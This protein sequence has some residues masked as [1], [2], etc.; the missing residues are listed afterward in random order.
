VARLSFMKGRP[1]D[2]QTRAVVLDAA[3]IPKPVT[4]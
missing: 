4:E 3:G 2:L 1:V